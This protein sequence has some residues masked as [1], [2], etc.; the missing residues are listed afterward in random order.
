MR[1]N[2]PSG[3]QR[4]QADGV[5]EMQT[6]IAQPIAFDGGERLGHAV[7][8]RLYA[9]KSGVRSLPGSGDHGFAA[10]KADFEIHLSDGN[11]EESAKRGGRRTRRDRVRAG[12]A[13]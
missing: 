8:E 13:A 5:V 9:D 11:R 4:D 6:H 7:D 3:S 12:A 1:A 10:A 2:D